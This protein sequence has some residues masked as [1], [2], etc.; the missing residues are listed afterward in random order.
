MFSVITEKNKEISRILIKNYRMKDADD[1]KDMLK[2]LM[3]GTIKIMSEIGI[4]YE[5]EYTKNFV[6]YKNIYSI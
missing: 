6:S 1:I 3:S 2:N 5:L 4:E